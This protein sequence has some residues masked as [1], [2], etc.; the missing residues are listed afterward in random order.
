[1]RSLPYFTVL[2]C[3]AAHT[4]TLAAANTLI[5][6][7]ATKDAGIKESFPDN[8]YGN[9][10]ISFG[11][12]AG[13]GP[14]GPY[15]GVERGLVDF[16]LDSVVVPTGSLLVKATLVLS[17]FPAFGDYVRCSAADIPTCATVHIVTTPWSDGASNDREAI[18]GESSWRY[19]D[20]ST[21]WQSPGGDF[22]SEP[23]G[24]R[25]PEILIPNPDNV[26]SFPFDSTMLQP[27]LDNPSSCH[28][29]LL[30]NDGNPGSVFFNS[31]D[32]GFTNPPRLDLE[33][34]DPPPT[35]PATQNPS[36]APVM[37]AAPTQN[38]T[39]APSSTRVILGTA[40]LTVS[41]IPYVLLSL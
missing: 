14:S 13:V 7:N 35:V 39:T 5:S 16:D 37:S 8:N 11:F 9:T 26:G 40:M 4:A 22:Q 18:S 6:L 30:Q 2:F 33:F 38:P 23:L 36:A 41:L 10:G 20:R 12:F 3:G 15:S 31:R 29:F 1:M 32:D 34:S 21:E 25:D 24:T 19:S 28:G 17:M 27:L